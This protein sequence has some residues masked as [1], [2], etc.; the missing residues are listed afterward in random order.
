MKFEVLKKYLIYTFLT[1]ISF[2]LYN[3]G[4]FQKTYSYTSCDSTE[5]VIS[6]LTRNELIGI[7]DTTIVKVNGTLLENKEPQFGTKL[8]FINILTKK[9]DSTE[10]DFDGNYNIEL[11]NG[12]Y[13]IV[14]NTKYERQTDLGKFTFKSGELR[15]LDFDFDVTEM[16]VESVIEFKSK[17]DYKRYLEKMER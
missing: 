10:T 4:I 1:G 2:S 11:N 5:T 17:R 16:F 8:K 13:E 7:Q 15:I 12:V 6:N 9:I 3:C 14:A